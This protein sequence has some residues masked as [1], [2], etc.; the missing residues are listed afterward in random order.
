VVDIASR[1][2]DGA[3]PAIGAPPA[4]PAAEKPTRSAR[5]EAAVE[6]I[7]R[8]YGSDVYFVFRRPENWVR[9]KL[10]QPY[11]TVAASVTMGLVGVLLRLGLA[12]IATGLAG[13]WALVNWAGWAIVLAFYAFVDSVARLAMPPLD[14]PAR[15]GFRA[16]VDDA[17]AL[18]PTLTHE[19]DAVDLAAFTRKWARLSTGALGGTLVTVATLGFAWLLMPDALSQVAA[20]TLVLVAL[21]LFDFGAVTVTPI[22]WALMSREARCD[23]DLFW[24]S[25]ADSPE[26]GRALST[27][28]GFA[29]ATGLWM[30]LYMILTIVLVSWRSPLVLPIAAGF[31]GFGYVVVIITTFGIRGSIRKIVLRA[32]E[33]QLVP[34]RDRIAAFGP[35]TADLSPV[36]SAR[37]RD[38]LDL[39][40]RIRESPDTIS[41]SHTVLHTAA[42][43]LVPTVMF[44]ISVSGEV[45]AERILDTIL[46]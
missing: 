27:N 16:M 29:W 24:A 38:L 14:E 18:L 12:L 5:F 3:A 42:G 17:M 28:V 4:A 15:P 7:R 22:E 26:V 9:R 23:H 34:L 21:L 45:Y 1:T 6:E 43:L 8:R 33:R 13:D 32:R 31:T 20:G 37:L 10:G 40:T 44:L 46:P 41:A 35:R 19:S 2:D 11:D 30:T 39:Y 36:E 25:P